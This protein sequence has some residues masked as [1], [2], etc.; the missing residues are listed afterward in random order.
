VLT[1]VA[2]ARG[3]WPV[4]ARPDRLLGEA[5]ALWM[6]AGLAVLVVVPHLW[7]HELTAVVT[8]AAVLAARALPDR[9]LVVAGIAVLAPWHLGYLHDIRRPEA[10]T[11]AQAAVMADLRASQPAGATVVSDDPGVVTWAG[12]R[13]PGRLVDP[14][15][16]LFGAG[17]VTPALVTAAAE[18]PGTCAMVFFSRRFDLSGVRPPPD[19]QEVAVYGRYQRLY[20]RRSCAPLRPARG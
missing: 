15:Y 6:A 12:M 8:P 3:R 10:P 4:R 19:Y 5:I 14:S 2:S 9:W 16:V 11:A 7:A 13:A 18:R 17:R 20:L 1:A